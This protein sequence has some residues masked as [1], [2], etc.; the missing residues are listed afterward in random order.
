MEMEV[1]KYER[2]KIQDREGGCGCG[3]GLDLGILDLVLSQ[4]N[5]CMGKSKLLGKNVTIPL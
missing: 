2:R 1:K 5:L 3:R 4:D